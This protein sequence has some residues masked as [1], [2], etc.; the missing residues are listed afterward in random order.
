MVP[1]ADVYLHTPMVPCCL[2]CGALRVDM[3]AISRKTYCANSSTSNCHR[4]RTLA[5]TPS[6]NTST[7]PPRA[8]PPRSSMSPV[9][10]WAAGICTPPPPAPPPPPLAVL[11]LPPLLTAS[12]IAALMDCALSTS[13]GALG[14]VDSTLSAGE[15]DSDGG[16]G[17]GRAAA[18]APSAAVTKA[19]AA[20]GAAG[21]SPSASDCGAPSEGV[22]GVDGCGGGGGGPLRALPRSSGGV[23]AGSAT[24]LFVV[25]GTMQ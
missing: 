12:S 14:G 5:I 15:R 21:R 16:E 10:S 17:N 20:S 22:D 23:V 3:F 4:A 11:P 7:P 19:A 9:A 24:W 1:S 8:P 13:Q 25:A 18:A 6:G 2:W